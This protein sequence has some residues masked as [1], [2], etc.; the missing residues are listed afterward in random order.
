M[1]AG[2]LECHILLPAGDVGR[3]GNCR[4]VLIRRIR[5]ILLRAETLSLRSRTE[6]GG[7]GRPMMACECVLVAL[8]FW[9]RAESIGGS[10]FDRGREP[11]RRR[12][13]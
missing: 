4:R 2:I 8:E 1:L 5:P 6:I 10:W 11:P 13:G 9:N 12:R 3:A 7:I